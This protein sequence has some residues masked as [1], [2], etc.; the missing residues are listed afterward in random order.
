MTA[1]LIS[2]RV[3]FA[4]AALWRHSSWRRFC[5]EEEPAMTQ[6]ET[7]ELVRRAAAGDELAWRRNRRVRPLLRHV[8][9]FWSARRLASSP[10]S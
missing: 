2:L 6:Q 5:H 9:L 7:A 3:L 1:V 10:T 4:Q 8:S